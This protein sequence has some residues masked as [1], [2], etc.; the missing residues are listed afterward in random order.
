MLNS[1]DVDAYVAERRE[2]LMREAEANRLARQVN[3]R[4][5]GLSL[6]R[7]LS[8]LRPTR[9]R[10]LPVFAGGRGRCWSFLPIFRGCPKIG[11]PGRA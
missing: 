7:L 9:V 2:R 1:Y 11:S 8:R 4:R 10:R 3:R 5:P 6:K